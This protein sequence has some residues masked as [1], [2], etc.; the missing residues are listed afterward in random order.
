VWYKDVAIELDKKKRLVESD[1]AATRIAYGGVKE[2]L[3]K[4]EIT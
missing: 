4:S 3:L 2:A 1:L